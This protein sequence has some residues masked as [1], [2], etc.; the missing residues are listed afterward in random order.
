[1]GSLSDQDHI[2]RGM[3]AALGGVFVIALLIWAVVQDRHQRA[4]VDAGHCTKIAEALYTPPPT[5]H[6]SCHGAGDS[7]Y[8][9]TR[10][11]Q[12]DPYMRSLWR[13]ADPAEAGRVSEFW[14]R[15]AEEH[16]R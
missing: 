7:R 11:H 4:L 15:T 9:T 13:C 14:R 16:G 3:A 2:A 6:M 8:C 1:M 10:Y 5:G 12:P